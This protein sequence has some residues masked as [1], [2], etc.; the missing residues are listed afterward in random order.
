MLGPLASRAYIEPFFWILFGLTLQK[1]H[2]LFIKHPKIIQAPVFLQSMLVI[3]ILAYGITTAIPGAFSSSF[4]HQ[5]MTALSDGYEIMKW[6]D[7]A[8][9]KNAIILSSHHSLGLATRKAVSL[10]WAKH[11]EAKNEEFSRYLERIKDEKV[12]HLLLYGEN[13]SKSKLY[14]TFFNCLGTEKIGPGFGH[15]ATRNPFNIGKTYEAWLYSFDYKRLP[16]CVHF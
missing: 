16:G 14:K 6:V 9:P 2:T 5:T 8:L 4:R 7:Q 11:T 12:T 10:D 13:V 1:P 15:R 3:S